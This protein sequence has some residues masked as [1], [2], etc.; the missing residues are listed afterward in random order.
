MYIVL[1]VRRT[2]DNNR[3]PARTGGK[4]VGGVPYLATSG[5]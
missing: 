5:R 3:T 1:V 4:D 2:S